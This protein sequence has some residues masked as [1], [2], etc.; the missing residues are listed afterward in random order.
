MRKSTLCAALPLGILAAAILIVA[1]ER[2]GEARPAE[3]ACA[4]ADRVLRVYSAAA[5]PPGETRVALQLGGPS[6]DS[7]RAGNVTQGSI[8]DLDRRVTA[9]EDSATF[10]VVSDAGK[11][12]FSVGRGGVRVFNSAG[13]DVADLVASS[14]GGAITTRSSYARLTAT[15]KAEDSGTGFEVSD[16]GV[17]YLDLGRRPSGNHSLIIRNKTGAQMAAIGESRAGTGGLQVRDASGNL[18]VS[19]GVA[20]GKGRIVI[21]NAAGTSVAALRQGLAGGV[22]EMASSLGDP[23]VKMGTK[24]GFYGV[25]LTGP[26]AGCPY[27]PRSGLPGSYMLGCAGGPACGPEGGK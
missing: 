27:V 10:A 1:H 24:S 7:G 16:G 17:P 9:L 13:T 20:E 12:I 19:I 18:A 25:V 4:G 5:C 3:V 11:P 21:D 14:E 26:A 15:L 23:V 8:G 2:T 22:L 6:S